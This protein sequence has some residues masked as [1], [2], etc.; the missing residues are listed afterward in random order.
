MRLCKLPHTH[1]QDKPPANNLELQLNCG[2]IKLENFNM[3]SGLKDFIKNLPKAELHIHLEGALEPELM[4]KFAERNRI[5]LKWESPDELRKK[6]EFKSLS[7]FLEVYFK[8]CEVIRTQEDFFELATFYLRKAISQN[9]RHAEIFLGPQSFMDKGVSLNDIFDGVF[10]AQESLKDKIS[11]YILPS[12]LRTRPPEEAFKLLEEMRPWL[13]K[14]RGVG[15]G[16]AEKGH[17]TQGFSKYFR[18]CKELGLK[19]TVHAGEETSAECIQEAIQNI[20]PDRIDH[21]LKA[22]ESRE[23]MSYL[24]EVRIPITLCPISN[25]KLKNVQS[26]ENLPI[27]EFMKAGILLTINSDDPA[28][29]SAYANENYELCARTFELDKPKLCELAKNSFEASFLPR[30]RKDEFIREVD[31]YFLKM[32]CR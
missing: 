13:S 11:S 12:V 31:E 17:P 14:I 21:G 2:E 25:I 26:A 23:L 15:M 22:F 4:F 24:S 6:L 18:R 30:E 7:D 32:K 27:R 3:A 19:T 29:F 5:R 9:V 16:G 1:L 10:A 28:Y 20:R 8:A